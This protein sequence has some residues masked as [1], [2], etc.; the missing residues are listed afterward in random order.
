M[1]RLAINSELHGRFCRQLK[2][3]RLHNGWTQTA[4]AK[5]MEVR[6]AYV[7][8]LES[9]VNSPSLDTVEEVAGAF[10]L[11]PERFMYFEPARAAEKA[12]A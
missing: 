3:W 2:A 11:T 6:P 8:Q 5:V 7:S 10:G 4:L 9:G 1:T 12:L